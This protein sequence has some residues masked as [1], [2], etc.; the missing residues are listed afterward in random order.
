MTAAI[1]SDAM[2]KLDSRY[3][4]E[5]LFY[6]KNR[7]LKKP[8]SRKRIVILTAAAIA[9]MALCGFAVYEL[10]PFD[11][12]LQKSSVDPT[13]TVQS[14]IEGQSDKEYT[15]AVQVEEIKIDED[16]TARVRARYTDSDLARARGWTGAYLAEHFI[17]VR[18]KYHVEYDHTKT[19]LD[20]GTIEQ[21]F[22]LTRDAKTGEWIVID[23]D[24]PRAGTKP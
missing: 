23:N 13:K 3:V 17:V 7:W 14:A 10:G 21:Y 24:S 18:A 6:D 2:G 20:D 15:I 1:F 4:N 12:W 8:G 5:A 22:Y 19:F 16:E 9:L 11:L